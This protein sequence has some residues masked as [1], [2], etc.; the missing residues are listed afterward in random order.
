MQLTKLPLALSKAQAKFKVPRKNS[1]AYNYKYA[2]LHEVIESVREALAENEL[3]YF[4]E[5][6]QEETKWMVRTTLIHSSGESISTTYPI[7]MSADQKQNANQLFGASVTYGRRYSLSLLLGVAADED[8]DTQSVK[9][10][11]TKQPKPSGKPGPIKPPPKDEPPIEELPPEAFD[12]HDDIPDFKD[13]KKVDRVEAIR[14]ISNKMQ[15]AKMT[16]ETGA[17]WIEFQLGHRAKLMD[18]NNAELKT[19]A[20]ALKLDLGGF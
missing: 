17:Q 19:L 10:E 1:K 6:I 20:K 5:T 14:L 4:H 16:A 15:A 11:D 12:Q 7:F 8:D 2:D 13:E 9:P 3:A 18:C